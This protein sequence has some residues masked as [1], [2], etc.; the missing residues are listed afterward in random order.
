[1]LIG[2]LTGTLGIGQRGHHVRAAK[3][4]HPLMLRR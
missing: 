2:K 1:M 3:I 4:D